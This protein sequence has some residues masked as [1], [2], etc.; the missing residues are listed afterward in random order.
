MLKY[1]NEAGN[2]QIIIWDAFKSSV[3]VAMPPEND[4]GVVGLPVEL[5]NKNTQHL[6]SPYGNK[7]SC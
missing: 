3:V 7:S 1:A 2:V 6:K 4:P 5:L